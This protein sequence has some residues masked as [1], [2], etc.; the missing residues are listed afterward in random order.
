[1]W[2]ITQIIESIVEKLFGFKGPVQLTYTDKVQFGDLATNVAMQIASLEKRSP[3]EI[4]EEIKVELVKQAIFKK[5]E[6]AGPGFINLTLNDQLLLEQI[7]AVNTQK[8][9]HLIPQKYQ[10]KTVIA[11]YSDP[12]PFKVLHVGHFYTSVIGDAIANL[13]ELAG[14][15]VHRVNFGGDVGL[16]VAKTI[17]A[18]LDDLG[19][20]VMTELKQVAKDERANLMGRYYVLGARAYEDDAEAKEAITGLN[21]QIYQLHVTK[22]ETSLLG[23]VYWLCR[24]W[25]YDYFDNFYAQIGVKFEKYYPESAVA[26]IGLKTVLEQKERGVFEES[27]GAVIFPGEKYGLHT[28]VFVNQQGLPTYESKEIGLSLAKDQDYR[29]DESVIVTGNE[30]VDYMKVVL[31]SIEQFRPD[32][33]RRTRHLTHGHVRLAGGVKMAS[34]Q[35]NF[36]KAV[37]ALGLVAEANQ[38]A[39]GKD[40]PETVLGAIKY[41]FLK[42]RIGADIIFEPQESVS[43]QGN[44]GPYLQYSLVRAKA[45]LAK[46]GQVNTV[47]LKTDLID[48]ERQISL[49]LSEYWQV[50][51]E[52]VEGLAPHQL[53]TYLYELAQE[54]NRFYE[55]SPV[56][57]SD[58]QVVRLAI[59][60]A[61]SYILEQGLLTLGV[62]APERM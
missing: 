2:N 3:R 29:F 43:L 55:N 1:M 9:E 54:F 42:N 60:K 13:I 7:Q 31:K 16:H 51:T 48:Y 35:G 30:I 38:Q 53:C 27:E 39:T 19:D 40:Q 33:A 26:S 56:L 45:I 36:L 61:Y 21:T 49:K 34:R 5:V 23:Q 62:P 58:R 47:D 18:M 8:T 57:G 14:G 17:W 4:A 46:A 12:N 52:A 22:D 20:G 11:E 25:S 44:S 37:E 24:Q 50:L 15:T 10:G 41:T 32:L 59:V 6:V 28:R